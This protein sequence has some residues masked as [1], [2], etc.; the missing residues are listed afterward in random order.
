MTGGGVPEMSNRGGG[1]KVI[2]QVP[3]RWA[4]AS[5]PRE[6]THTPAMPM[7]TRA[8]R[9]PRRAA[10]IAI[11]GRATADPSH[12][13]RAPAVLFGAAF[14]M[15]CDRAGRWMHQ[16]R[17]DLELGC[18]SADRRDAIAVRIIGGFFFA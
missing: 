3:L 5:F 18:V 12:R 14:H 1:R 17:F 2:Y 15:R 7:E 8:W 13:S 6:N 11:G 4:V 9:V 16:D 10:M